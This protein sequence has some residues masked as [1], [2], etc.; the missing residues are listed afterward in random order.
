[1][2]RFRGVG[3]GRDET[4]PFWPN[5]AVMGLLAREERLRASDPASAASEPPGGPQS[6]ESA[7]RGSV[8][9]R[10]LPEQRPGGLVVGQSGGRGVLEVAQVDADALQLD[11]GVVLFALLV[12]TD[13]FQ[14]GVRVALHPA[15]LVVLVRAGQA[16]VLP[17]VVERVAVDV[18]DQ[19]AGRGL[20]D[21][22]VH[23][24]QGELAVAIG[25]ETHGVAF[26]RHEP[27]VLGEAGVVGG[28]DE[29]RRAALEG[30]GL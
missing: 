25:E 16:Q 24:Q 22:A 29:R 4:P 18:I 11:A 27:G 14:P 3:Q 6:V 20:Q 21:D 1:M 9:T 12:P 26:L 28:V 23:V 7:C 15:V 19:L 5:S 8:G 30:N 2:A 10:E 13:A 17:A